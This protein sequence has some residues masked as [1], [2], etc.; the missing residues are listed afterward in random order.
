MTPSY[1]ELKQRAQ[2]LAEEALAE[3]TEHP[4]EALGL[5]TRCGPCWIS[6]DWLATQRAKELNYYGGFEY[7]EPEHMMDLGDWTF[8]SREADRV[9]AAISCVEFIDGDVV[10][11]RLIDYADGNISE[12]DQVAL[13][14]DIEEWR[15]AGWDDDRI[16]RLLKNREEVDP[17]LDEATALANMHRIMGEQS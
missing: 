5:D 12:E 13:V 6:E 15:E 16:F 14:R 3:A 11:S 7:I 17:D 9:D 2:A 8:Y 1:Y 10:L 4:A